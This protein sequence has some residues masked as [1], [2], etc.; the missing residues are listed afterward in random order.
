[1]AKKIDYHGIIYRVGEFIIV[2]RPSGV[3]DIGKITSFYKPNEVVSFDTGI[4]HGSCSW[5]DMYCL[6]TDGSQKIQ[7]LKTGVN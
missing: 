7:N 1:M 2:Q 6:N 3:K 4:F 5:F